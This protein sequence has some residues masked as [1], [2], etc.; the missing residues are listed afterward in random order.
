PAASPRVA[1]EPGEARSFAMHGRE[2]FFHAGET[3]EID[4]SRPREHPQ[5]E[6]GRAPRVAVWVPGGRSSRSTSPVVAITARGLVQSRPVSRATSPVASIHLM[7]ERVGREPSATGASRP[8]PSQGTVTLHAANARLD[9]KPI[10]SGFGGAPNTHTTS[11]QSRGRAVSPGPTRG[12]PN[13]ERIIPSS[14]EALSP[15]S[16]LLACIAA[17]PK[18]APPQAAA[19]RLQP[20]LHERPVQ[21]QLH[22]DTCSSADQYDQHRQPGSAYGSSSHPTEE[23]SV[24]GSDNGSR[25][26]AKRR[27]QNDDADWGDGRRKTHSSSNTGNPSFANSHVEVISNSGSATTATGSGIGSSSSRSSSGRNAAGWR[28][29]T[30][31][32]SSSQLAAPALHAG[33]GPSSP[34]ANPLKAPTASGPSSLTVADSIGESSSKGEYGRPSLAGWLEN[35]GQ[36]AGGQDVIA[37]TTVMGPAATAASGRPSAVTAEG[38]GEAEG[39]NSNSPSQS[40]SDLKSTGSPMGATSKSTGSP[41]AEAAAAAAAAL[42]R[43]RDQRMQRMQRSMHHPVY[44]ASSVAPQRSR[45]QQMLLQPGSSGAVGGD[46]SGVV[47][48]ALRG[49][50]QGEV[51]VSPSRPMSATGANG[52]W[53]LSAMGNSRDVT[54]TADHAP[55][56]SGGAGSG[57]GTGQV[58]M[59]L[60]I[61]GSASDGRVGTAAAAPVGDD[62]T[63]L[64]HGIRPGQLNTSTSVPEW[65]LRAMRH[66]M[67]PSSGPGA[68]MPSMSSGRSPVSKGPTSVDASYSRATFSRSDSMRMGGVAGA[69]NGWRM[70]GAPETTTGHALD[71]P[72]AVGSSRAGSIGPRVRNPAT[73]QMASSYQHS[74]PLMQLLGQASED[75]QL[76]SDRL[77]P[78]VDARPGGNSHL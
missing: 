58:T 24:Y 5:P 49:S 38:K 3:E 29:A 47:V 36:R 59:H 56:N 25:T 11:V 57:C 8:R 33:P 20:Q 66:E 1:T 46:A 7:A 31:R 34:Q 61:S 22:D 32:I 53:P 4:C 21:Y 75:L 18:K 76:L 12:A 52:V 78:L 13:N 69:T 23:S 63:A 48:L 35:S 19:G 17:S 9:A 42:Q 41:M 72:V 2:S 67:R 40:L 28:Q 60:E 14:P 50:L 54:G 16:T 45:D 65:N 15:I 37:S 77:K 62:G 10:G 68:D 51:I 55:A 6:R 30:D 73:A 43:L 27:H 44:A 74:H 26:G 70:E 71:L 64:K 39:V